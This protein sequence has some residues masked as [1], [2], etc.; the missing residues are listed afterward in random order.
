LVT[1]ACRPGG[2]D[3]A[4]RHRFD[5]ECRTVTDPIVED[6]DSYLAPSERETVERAKDF[7]HRV[8]APGARA[9]EYERRHPTEA[10]RAACAEDLAGIELPPAFGGRGQ[11]FSTKMRVVEELARH[12]FGFAFSLVNHHNAIVRV[13]GGK[14]A[15]AERLVPR[16]LRGEMIGCSAYTEADHGSDLAGLTTSATK[17]DGGWTLR[18]EKAWICNASVADVIVTLA[19]TRPSA[20]S[21]GIASFVV[22]S[23]RPG[24]VRQSAYALHGAHA[25]GAGGLGLENY[26]APD[27]ALLDPP[28]TAFKATLCGIN[29]ARCYVAAMCAG[30]LESAIEHAVRYACERRAFGKKVIDFQGLRWSL[31]DAQTD[32]AALRLLTYR[33][34]RQIDVRQSAEESAAQ[35]K[36]FAG[37]RTIG[38]VAACI[39]AMGANGL[40]SDHP[41]MRHLAGCKAACFT[42]G[43]TE[44]MNERLGTLVAQRYTTLPSAKT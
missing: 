44:M 39:Q 6:F 18:G 22:E 1:R 11:R 16:M 30:M 36:K 25:I 32:L 26:L 4:D 8:V 20:G 9:W 41:L 31:V 34:A 5:K 24:F 7:G 3:A 12:D 10:L 29:G 28:G 35:A 17:V 42:D 40:R 43:T 37:D 14:P 21:K 2:S 27:D 13:A 33:A 23:G 38:H 19:Q 15:L